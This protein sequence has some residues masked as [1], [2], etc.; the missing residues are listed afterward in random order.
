MSKSDIIFTMDDFIINEI[1]TLPITKHYC[2]EIEKITTKI[3][4]GEYTSSEEL[5]K[6]CEKIKKFSDGIQQFQSLQ[7]NA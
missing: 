3:R 6:L 1:E 4:R 7:T 5:I 2:C